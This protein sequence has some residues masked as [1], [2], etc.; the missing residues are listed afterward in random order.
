MPAYNNGSAPY[1]TWT[2]E[3]LYTTN[4]WATSGD[5]NYDAAF[6]VMAEN[7]SGQSLTQVVGGTPIAFNLARG[8]SYT[9]YGYPAASPSTA[10]P[11]GRAPVRSPRTRSVA[12]RTRACRAT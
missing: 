2:A 11:C 10:R 5:F 12:A 1:G 6:A 8:L 3:T 7:G 9:A 4:A